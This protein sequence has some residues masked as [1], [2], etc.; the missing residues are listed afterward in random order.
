MIFWINSLLSSAQPTGRMGALT[1]SNHGLNKKRWAHA[2]SAVNS[3]SRARERKTFNISKGMGFL[4]IT[5]GFFSSLPARLIF[6]NV[7]WSALLKVGSVRELD[8]E[9]QKQPFWHQRIWK[10]GIFFRYFASNLVNFVTVNLSRRLLEYFILFFVAPKIYY[11][12]QEEGTHWASWSNRRTALITFS[13]A[14]LK[15]SFSMVKSNQ[16]PYT[17]SILSPALI[18]L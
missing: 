4:A 16:W 7:L 18:M 15:S 5:T 2:F 12:T 6:C 14:T 11:W 3:S 9:E 13:K 10:K 1:R 17:R 8:W